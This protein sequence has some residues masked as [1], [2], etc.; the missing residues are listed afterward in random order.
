MKAVSKT[1]YYCAGVRMQDAE[2]DHPLIG[3]KYAKRLL[4]EEGL[5][6]W[7][8]FK[9]FN[10]PNMGNKTRAYLIDTLLKKELE[11]HP[12]ATIILIGA[13]LDSR[14]C[15]IPSGNWVEIDESAIIDY[16]NNVLPVNECMNPLERIPIDFEK[17][18]LYNK[19]QRYSN[20][21]NV[22]FIIEGVLMYLTKQQKDELLSTLITLFPEHT[23]FCDLMKKR[24]FEKFSQDIHKKLVEHG[25]SFSDISDEPARLFLDKGYTLIKMTGIPQAVHE[26]GI[27]RIPW[28]IRKLVF[29]DL[30]TGYSVYHFK[31]SQ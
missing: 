27:Q 2:S 29:G 28:L 30:I 22:I 14:A 25:T 12:N 10:R 8:E 6:Y 1:A 21:P 26:L 5:A 11:V 4:G 19:L 13:G 31:H 15:R 7:E 24:F 16:K 18:K 17:D 23:L 9:N 3:D 20:R